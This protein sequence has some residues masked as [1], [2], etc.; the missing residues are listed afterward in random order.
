MPLNPHYIVGIT[1]W[2]G[3][4]TYSRSKGGVTLYFGIKSSDRDYTLLLKVRDYFSVGKVYRGGGKQ[5]RWAYYRVNRLGDLIKIVNHFER[6]PLLGMKQHA[7][8]IWKGMVDCKRRK[9]PADK[10][11]ISDFAEK[12]SR[13]SRG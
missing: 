10:K 6:Y 5:D 13:F 9:L 3:S 1:E 8:A 7:F 12:L 2:G 4:F 11:R